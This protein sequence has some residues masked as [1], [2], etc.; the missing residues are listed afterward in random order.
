MNKRINRVL[1]TSVIGLSLQRLLST[2][3]YD[4]F[5]T[6]VTLYFRVLRSS[7]LLLRIGV[8]CVN[9]QQRLYKSTDVKGRKYNHQGKTQQKQN[10]RRFVK[11]TFSRKNYR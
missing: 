3:I 7:S 6:Y 1:K 8:L 10:K 2:P 9:K 5:V 4:W 11:W